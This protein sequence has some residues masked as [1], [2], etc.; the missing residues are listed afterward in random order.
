[1]P[2]FAAVR[3]FSSC[4]IT[5]RRMRRAGCSR[6]TAPR[7]VS[8]T[9]PLPRHR[10]TLFSGEKN[11][12]LPASRSRQRSSGRTACDRSIFAI[13]AATASR[14]RRRPCGRTARIGARY[15]SH[16]TCNDVG[17]RTRTGEFRVPPLVFRGMTLYAAAEPCAMCAAAIIWSG[18]GRVVFGVSASRLRLLDPLPRGLVE[19]GIGG[20]AVLDATSRGPEVVGPI[21]E[22]EGEA[23]LFPARDLRRGFGP[24]IRSV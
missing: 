5:P 3:P 10:K 19:P 2:F 14:S 9:S 24:P 16:Q 22:D 12:P 11:S 21:L 15:E 6:L 20:R 18:V 8:A 7:S 1:M 13:Q 17:E 23:A 4:S